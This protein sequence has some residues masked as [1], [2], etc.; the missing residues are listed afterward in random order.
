MVCRTSCLVYDGN[1]EYWPN[2]G[3]GDWGKRISHAQQPALPYGY[4]PKRILIGDVDGDGLADIVYVDDT[5]SHAVDQP[6]RQPLERSDR[7]R[8]HPAGHRI[9]MPCVWW[10]CSAAASAACCGAPMRMVSRER[11]LFFLDFTGGRETVSAARD[12][13]PHRRGEQRSSTRPPPASIWRIR[14]DP[15]RAGRRRCRFRSRWSR[16]SKSSTQFS[17][18]SSPPNTSYHH[19]YWDGAEREFRGFGR[20]DQV[21]T[22][23]FED[24]NCSRIAP[25]RNGIR[26]E[27]RGVAFRRPQRRERGFIRGRSATSL[28][29]GKRSTSVMNFGRAMSRS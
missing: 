20:V 24:F 9:W 3:H 29:S 2:L 1:V 28:A 17:E 12:G 5:Q 21:D 4:D 6:E 26:V 22:E 10:M 25:R 14:S 18:A 8:W 7:D 11:T 15:R 13:Q 27:S 23:V 16:A 19:G